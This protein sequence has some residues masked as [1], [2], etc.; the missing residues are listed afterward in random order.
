MASLCQSARTF[1]LANT[2]TQMRLRHL[3]I[4]TDEAQ[5]Y[6]RLASHVLWTDDTLR[7]RPSILAGNTLGH[8]KQ[9][10]LPADRVQKL[11]REPRGFQPA[12][13]N[14]RRVGL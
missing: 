7:A 11:A 2:Q 5:L 6:E 3:G 14:D 9:Q 4:S 12:G 13:N 1:A 10:R 8:P